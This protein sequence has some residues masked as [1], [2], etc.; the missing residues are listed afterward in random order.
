MT[1]QQIMAIIQK[2]EARRDR[3]ARQLEITDT[4]LAHWQGMLDSIKRGK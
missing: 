2:L 1:A 3:Q 4:E